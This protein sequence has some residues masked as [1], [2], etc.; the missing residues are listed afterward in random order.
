MPAPRP[1]PPR[2]ASCAQSGSWSALAGFRPWGIR[3]SVQR[4]HNRAW[5][6]AKLPEGSGHD[7]VPARPTPPGKRVMLC[8]HGTTDQS[9][10]PEIPAAGVIEHGD[11]PPGAAGRRYRAARVARVDGVAARRRRAR[12]GETDLP[13]IAGFP[14]RQE[15][16]RRG[17]HPQHALP[18]HDPARPAAGVSR[19][20]RDGGAD[21]EHPA[22]ECDGDGAASL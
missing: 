9:Q 2:S 1:T 19:R 13:C 21:R 22:L 14:H 6:G 20:R 15:R 11:P 18:Q 16:D 4:T 5:R 12:P 17:S 3:H 8:A 10:A 7:P